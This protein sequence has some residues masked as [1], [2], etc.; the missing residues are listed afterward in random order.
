MPLNLYI[1]MKNSECQR[2]VASGRLDRETLGL[3]TWCRYLPLKT[4]GNGAVC[5]FKDGTVFNADDMD[6]DGVLHCKC[7]HLCLPDFVIVDLFSA[8]KL[9]KDAKND[10]Y[11]LYDTALEIGWPGDVVYNVVDFSLG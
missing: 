10:G 5:T 4:S 6:N 1:A 2:V 7:L 3:P 9:T 8:G 11:R